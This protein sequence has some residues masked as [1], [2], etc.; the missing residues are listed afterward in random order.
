MPLFIS[1]EQLSKNSTLFKFR[2]LWQIPDF[3]REIQIVQELTKSLLNPLVDMCDMTNEDVRLKQLECLNEIL[4]SRGHTLPP[5]A[6]PPV[7]FIL[8]SVV[9]VEPAAS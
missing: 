3:Y 1:A 7:L 5:A 9:T 4:N 2:F 6:W 8:G